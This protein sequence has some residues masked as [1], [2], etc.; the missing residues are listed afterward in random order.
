M[1]YWI[2]PGDQVEVR[3]YWDNGSSS[4][5]VL[6][7]YADLKRG[8]MARVRFDSDGMETDYPTRC[9]VPRGVES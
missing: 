3:H 8:L 2:E 4:A 1:R 9:L 5:I 7:V 6:D